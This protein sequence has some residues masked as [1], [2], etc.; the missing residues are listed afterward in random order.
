MGHRRSREPS[1]FRSNIHSARRR[2]AHRCRDPVTKEHSFQNFLISCLETQIHIPNSWSDPIYFDFPGSDPSLFFDSGR[3][4]V[5]GSCREGP[6]WVPDCFIR[7]FEI[8]LETGKALSEIKLLWKGAH[9]SGDAEGPHIYKEDDWYYLVTAEGSTFEGHQINIARSRNLW[10]PYEGHTS[11]PLLTAAD[12]TEEVRW[13]GHGDL[14]E[15]TDGRWWCVHPGVRKSQ[16]S[17][18]RCPLGR[19]TFITPVSWEAGSWPKVTQTKLEFKVPIEEHLGDDNEQVASTVPNV[20]DLFI[21]TPDMSNYEILTQ[22][23][24]QLRPQSST[25][26]TAYGSTTFVGRRQRS[27]NCSVVVNLDLSSLSSGKTRAGLAVYKDSLRHAEIFFDASKQRIAFDT[28]SINNTK[29]DQSLGEQVEL[30]SSESSVV[31]LKID[32][33][34][35]Q[36]V[37]SWSMGDG[38]SGSTAWHQ[39]AAIDAAALSGHDMTGAIFGLFASTI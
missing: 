14:F 29:V 37:F 7:Q 4:Y 34:N 17:P 2:L 24:Y 35:G 39:V 12:T 25:M 28:I 10:G 32:A 22:D 33:C 5:Q 6:P 19:E 36:Y 9:P 3:A 18:M 1:H 8:D 26:S 27:L 20:E 15:D 13:T 38:K 11:N 16:T 21:R 31:A 23:S 30:Q